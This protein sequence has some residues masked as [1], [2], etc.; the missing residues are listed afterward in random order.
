MTHVE[1]KNIVLDEFE[2]RT[3]KTT[4]RVTQDLVLVPSRVPTS[5]LIS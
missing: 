1:Y 4:D 2:A 5:R 3:V